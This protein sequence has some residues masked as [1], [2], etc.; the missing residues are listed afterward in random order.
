MKN[1][2]REEAKGLYFQSGLS[3]TA[4]AAKVG[5]TRKTVL[6]WAQQGNWEKL[7]MSARSA[8]TIVAEKCYYLLNHYLNKMLVVDNILYNDNPPVTIKEAQAI[9]LLTS[10][11]KKL[12]NR[13]TINES[14]ELFNFFHSHVKGKDP[15][16]AAL[17]APQIEEYITARRNVNMADHLLEEFN[18]NNGTLFFPI[19]ERDEDFEDERDN[20]ELE[21]DFEEFLKTREEKETVTASEHPE[22]A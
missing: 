7:R 12:K 16:L 9:H 10:S 13:S 3:K 1:D 4:I 14:M 22:A 18:R 2:Q 6:F 15:E 19:K 11:I 17:M 5:V 20:P 8:P 21:K